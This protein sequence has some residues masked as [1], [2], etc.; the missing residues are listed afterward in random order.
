M[1]EADLLR[2]YNAAF[3]HMRAMEEAQQRG[4]KLVG[5]GRH[6]VWQHGPCGATVPS[7]QT[8]PHPCPHC[9]ARAAARAAAPTQ[10]P[11]L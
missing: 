3:E 5:Y 7:A 11:S 9:E 4:W 10:S 2:G 8:P 1:N 6:T